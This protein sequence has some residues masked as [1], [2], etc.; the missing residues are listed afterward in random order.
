MGLPSKSFQTTLCPPDLG[1]KVSTGCFCGKSQTEHRI[2]SPCHLLQIVASSHLL[3]LLIA[4][5]H[6]DILNPSCKERWKYEA[7][8]NVVSLFKLT[9]SKQ[10]QKPAGSCVVNMPL[11]V[12]P[13]K[14]LIWYSTWTQIANK[15]R[16]HCSYSRYPK[17]SNLI[18]YKLKDRLPV[19]K[20][21]Q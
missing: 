3:I 15:N 1:N 13:P 9:K 2:F 14:V 16:S 8:I 19:A 5:R 17:N 7:P 6:K 11:F 18:Y 12:K 20:D 21:T 4:T 10:A